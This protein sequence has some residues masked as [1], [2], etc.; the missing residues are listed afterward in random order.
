MPSGVVGPRDIAPF[1]PPASARALLTV[2]AAPGAA[3]MLDMAGFLE[4]EVRGWAVAAGEVDTR[5]AEAR[6][7][8]V[9]PIV[10]ILSRAARL[11]ESP[12]SR[13]RSVLTVR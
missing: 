9:Y 8:A 10:G 6:E 1:R 12:A 13:L 3:P 11:E 5:D 7:A 4:L 2:T